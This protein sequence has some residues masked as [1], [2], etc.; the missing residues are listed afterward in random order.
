MA[1]NTHYQ[2]ALALP[3]WC[4]DPAS[5]RRNFGCEQEKLGAGILET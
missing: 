3:G 5:P 4:Q 1:L 2:T